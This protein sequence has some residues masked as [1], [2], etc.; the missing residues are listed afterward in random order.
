MTDLERECA[1]VDELL[2][3][4]GLDPEQCRTDGG[5]INMARTRTLL[6][7]RVPDDKRLLREVFAVCEASE[8]ECHDSDD[9]FK[10]GR[11]FE[12]KRIRR[13]I[14]T[15]YQDTFCGRYFMGDPALSPNSDRNLRGRPLAWIRKRSD[16][17][18][19]GPIAD[20]DKRMDEVRRKSGAWTPL[21]EL[22]EMSPDFTDT[23]RAA[24]LWVLWHHQGGSSDI[25]QP[26]RFALGMGVRHATER[27]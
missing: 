9:A 23:A 11:A 25:G 16:G 12:A 1:A 20:A 3:V 13:S 10:R 14:G 2:R 8:D 6:S 27:H 21:Y 22:D 5:A 15:W 19:E 24:L 26:I 4:L 7:E 18:Y 17:G